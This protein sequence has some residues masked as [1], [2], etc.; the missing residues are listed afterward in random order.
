[1]E[2]TMSRKKS[3]SI[4]IGLAIALVYT[5]FS[6]SSYFF[7]LNT[8]HAKHIN[9]KTKRLV[10]TAKVTPLYK[11]KPTQ[12]LAAYLNNAVN[13]NL[14]D[15]YFLK[16]NKKTAF[17][18]GN[19]DALSLINQVAVSGN[20]LLKL[21]DVTFANI[22]FDDITVRLGIYTS[23]KSFLMAYFNQQK[24]KIIHDI[25][26]VVTLVMSVVLFF[27][28]EITQIAKRF[29]KNMHQSSNKQKFRF[30]E[31][32]VLFDT[33]QSYKRNVESERESADLLRNQLLPALRSEL[34]SGKKAPYD[35]ECTMI[36]TDINYFSTFFNSEKREIFM[37]VIDEFFLECTR[38]ISK[39]GGK[40][41]EF[42]G[43][44]IIFYF[45]NEDVG[46]SELIALS[47]V[48][49]I[50]LLAET[51]N[52]Y[53]QENFDFPFT[54]KSALSN[55][56][57]RFCKLIN[58]YGLAGSPFIQTVRILNLIEERGQNTVYLSEGVHQKTMHLCESKYLDTFQLKGFA[59][60]V[61][62]YSYTEHLSLSVILEKL[63]F[64]NV[65]AIS[66]YRDTSHVLQ[67]LR[68]VRANLL[69]DKNT[70]LLQAIAQLKKIEYAQYEPAVHE[71]LKGILDYILVQQSWFNSA[72]CA[73][74]TSAIISI[75]PNFIDSSRFDFNFQR[76]LYRF[77]KHTNFR[78]V[79]NTIDIFSVLAP[80]VELKGLNDLRQHHCNRVK[81]N[82]LL[83]SGLRNLSSEILGTIEN[84]L[85]S[86]DQRLIA[87]TIYALGELA[88]HYKKTNPVFFDTN[89]KLQFL[90]EKVF[91][92]IEKRNM[93]VRQQALLA[94]RKINVAKYHNRVHDLY[95]HTISLSMR[96]A[97]RECYFKNEKLAA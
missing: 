67:L 1:M 54:V 61:K 10:A 14:I 17:K 25:I 9:T 43:D 52:N 35:F 44:E 4:I 62:V 74:L 69:K 91:D 26:L 63:S 78:V 92:S 45:K 84:N 55:G 22:T 50:N 6:L 47:A 32:K 85:N 88:R 16:K 96:N 8:I 73:K 12:N 59:T 76:T 11:N 68:F 5:A 93:L 42:V 29:Q 77:M 13:N 90:I 49:D 56:T 46:E 89:E 18:N 23:K 3:A 51:L 21:E 58:R 20:K 15:F 39:Y 37:T 94:I 95:S 7:D 60:K 57:V 48:R 70:L 34:D 41:S 53:T 72:S 28:K 65:E 86:D 19:D 2:T 80:Q 97:I 87:S 36:R 64:A 24:Y 75:L 83:N 27:L 66:Y 81:A 30:H 31:E 38:I 40:V 71:E 79:A 82:A 33:L